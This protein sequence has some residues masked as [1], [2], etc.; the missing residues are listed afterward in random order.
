MTA[1]VHRSGYQRRDHEVADYAEY[2]FA[3]TGLW[4]RGPDPGPLPAGEQITYLGAAQTF[5]CFTSD[6]FPSQVSRALGAPGRNLG[7]GGAGPRFYLDHPA[8]IQEAN[9]GR[10]AVVQVMSARSEDNSLFASG[11]LERLQ[12]RSDGAMLG[13]NEAYAAIV[14]GYDPVSGEPRGLRRKL[15]SRVSRPKAKAVVAETRAN[16]T[17]S[18]RRLLAALDVPV[19]LV[20]ISTR[21][22]TYTERFTSAP[23]LFGAFPQLVNESMVLALRP[24]CAAYVQVVSNAGLPQPLFS[25][26]DGKPAVVEPAL[27]RADLG[28]E[29]WTHNRYYPSPQMHDEVAAAV[30][31]ALRPLIS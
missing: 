28:G 30:T 31:A 4:F 16:W 5:G 13:A 11:G 19:V 21:S 24:K 7:Y 3:G 27:D 17:E 20:W 22:P 18:Y 9:R 26:F 1:S 2:E 15:A 25:R 8:L 23:A 12:R 29:Q 10:A 6:P 14:G